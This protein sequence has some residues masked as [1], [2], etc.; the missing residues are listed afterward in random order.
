MFTR[1][2][3]DRFPSARWNINI[4]QELKYSKSIRRR[5][6]ERYQMREERKGEGGKQ[7]VICFPC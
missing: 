1:L 4:S 2:G 3:S 7:R 5:H 6:V